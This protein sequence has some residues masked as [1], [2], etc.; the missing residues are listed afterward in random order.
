[1]L[2]R[3]DNIIVILLLGCPQKGSKI[4]R[5]GVVHGIDHHVE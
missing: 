5:I 3:N 4:L 2:W 1:L